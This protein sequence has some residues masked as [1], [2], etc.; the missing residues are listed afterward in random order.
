MEKMPFHGYLEALEPWTS[1]VDPARRARLRE[2]CQRVPVL[3]GSMVTLREVEPADAAS[4]L[5]MLAVDEVARFISPPP[6]TLEGFE[7]F[8]DW[9][10]CQRAAGEYICFGVVP[11]GMSHAV[12]L[13]QVRR[14]DRSFECVEWGFAIGSPFW[15][16]GMFMDAGRLTV[17]FA[18]HTLGVRRLEARAAVNNGRGNG[19]LRKIGATCEGILRASFSRNG[20]FFDQVLWSILDSEWPHIKD[21]RSAGPRTH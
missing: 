19:A 13:F 16:T 5:G 3:P 18:M 10:H 20:V 12:G 14:M 8:I 1:I 15:G 11:L 17:D 21:L 7:R 9:A 4:L 2:L 6:T